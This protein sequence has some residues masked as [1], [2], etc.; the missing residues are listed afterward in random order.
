M[1]EAHLAGDLTV[2]SLDQQSIFHDAGV[3]D[4]YVE[5]PEVGHHRIECRDN[6]GLTGD[7]DEIT[8]SP[9]A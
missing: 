9:G 1:I 2:L 6:L 8:G 3:V 7:V 4:E 5:S